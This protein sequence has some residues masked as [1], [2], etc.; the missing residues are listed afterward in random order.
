[1][2]VFENEGEIDIDAITTFGVS[3]KLG[4]NPIGFFGTGLKYAIAVLLRTEHKVSIWSGDRQ[5]R[6]TTERREVRTKPFDFVLMREDDR[7]TPMGF[8]TE[9]G[10]TWKPWMAYR[11]LYCNARD[12]G[13]SVYRVA[14]P[15]AAT[16]PRRGQTQIRVEGAD[17][18]EV[19]ANGALYFCEGEPDVVV[20]GVGIYCRPSQV[21]F[22]RGVR[23]LFLPKPAQFTYNII[24]RRIDLTE[25]RTMTHPFMATWYLSQALAQCTDPAILEDL[26]APAKGALEADFDYA[27]HNTKATEVFLATISRLKERGASNI[28]GSALKVWA[29]DVPEQ[30]KPQLSPLDMDERNALREARTLCERLAFDVSD[31]LAVEETPA[32][33][34]T[35][36]QDGTLYLLR[37]RIDPA[38]I[39]TLAGDLIRGSMDRDSLSEAEREDRLIEQLLASIETAS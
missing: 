38:Y 27:E 34:P 5:L 10:K 32:S 37:S 13:G 33:T 9:L 20:G 24:D 4:E 36:V 3:V 19:H 12:E 2:I 29:R 7:L 25:D 1:M 11:E 22:Y 14:N 35:Y 21:L 15:N 16:D 17:V 30:F 8:T 18:Q 26:L 39:T 6:F 31:V 28:A 23:V